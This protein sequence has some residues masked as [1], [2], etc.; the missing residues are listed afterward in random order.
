MIDFRNMRDA[1]DL[2]DYVG[3]AQ[4]VV[5]RLL[6]RAPTSLF[7]VHQIPKRSRRGGFRTVWA[8]HDREVAD[9]FKSLRRRLDDFMFTALPNY[10]HRAAHG[11]IVGRSTRSN[12]AVHLGCPLIL[13]V[14]IKNF[15]HSIT[16]TR[17]Q[18]FLR[19]MKLDGAASE[20]LS[21]LLTFDGRLQ[22]GIHTS[23]TVANGV[24][25]EMDQ[26]IAALVEPFGGRYS[27]YADDLTFSGAQLPSRS[28]LVRVL[29]LDGFE[30]AE[31][32]L[33]TVRRGRGLFVTGLSL[34]AGDYP[35][36]PKEFKRR[37]RQELYY[38]KRY[39]VAQHIGSRQYSSLSSGVNKIQGRIQY[40]RGIERRLG[41]E[42]NTKW[43]KLLAD[44]DLEVSY[45]TFRNTGPRRVLF[46]VD[47]AVIRNS[48]LA[49]GLVVIEDRGFVGGTLRDFREW[50]RAYPGST[51][52]PSVFDRE[53]LHYNSLSEDLRTK[54]TEEI[55]RLPLRAFVVF[56]RL[57]GSDKDEYVATYV[58]LFNSLMARRFL[59]YDGCEVTIA[60]EKNSSIPEVQLRGAVS[61]NYGRLA[62]SGSRRP[63]SE[64]ALTIVG[65]LDEDCI[66]LPDAFLGVFE[67]YADLEH[68]RAKAAGEKKKT[69][70]GHQATVRFDLLRDKIRM[71][72]D[73]D[74][75]EVFSRRRPFRPWPIFTSAS[76]SP[77]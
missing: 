16:Q 43:S 77:S 33:R 71:I 24:C 57:T 32:K 49:L 45:P 42:L 7:V 74:S 62:G 18:A 26:R 3:C 60:V 31:E 63:A 27:R 37:L 15:F 67:A 70:P 12:A 69:L 11:Y 9:A 75:A 65:K 72:Q 17:V 66:S 4:N 40:L 54:L 5:D 73:L 13:K 64:P 59:L 55:A 47:E 35:R 46:C 39:G 2:A 21:K 44:A 1:R 10:P 22:L 14:D 28:E 58:R 48:V 51:T 6:G 29:A 19:Q 61:S 36:V 25:H 8:V 41:D 56:S 38:A 53:G 50:A 34:E 68:A 23:P 52:A 30:I 20:A 76:R